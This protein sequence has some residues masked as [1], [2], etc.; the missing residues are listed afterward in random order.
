MVF[1]EIVVMLT[2]IISEMSLLVIPFISLG[3]TLL[4]LEILIKF[5][6]WRNPS[7][8]ASL[9]IK[10]GTEVIKTDLQFIWMWIGIWFEATSLWPGVIIII[11]IFWTYTK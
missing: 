10:L 6:S 2:F 8:L 1:Y 7:P 9:N 3:E 11:I 4:R 5:K